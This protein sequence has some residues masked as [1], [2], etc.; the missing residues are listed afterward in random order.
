M[1]YVVLSF[2]LS[3]RSNSN[4]K[5]AKGIYSRNSYLKSKNQLNLCI[6]SHRKSI[7]VVLI[8]NSS[9]AVS[10]ASQSMSKLSEYPTNQR[11]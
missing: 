2:R 8:S 4:L 7:I 9:K 1:M 5:T 11:V 10:S 3:N 6:L